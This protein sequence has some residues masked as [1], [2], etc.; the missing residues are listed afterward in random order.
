MGLATPGILSLFLCQKDTDPTGRNSEDSNKKWS[1]LEKVDLW[2][3]LRRIGNV[4]LPH[5]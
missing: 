4:W 1:G 3:K 5:R 2:G